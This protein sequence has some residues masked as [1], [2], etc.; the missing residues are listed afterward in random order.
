VVGLESAKPLSYATESKGGGGVRYRFLVM[1]WK[2]E[3]FLCLALLSNS[4]QGL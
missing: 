2:M 4:L 1:I 3:R